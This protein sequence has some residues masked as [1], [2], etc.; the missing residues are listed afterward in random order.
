[1]P[2]L[3]LQPHR[4][5]FQLPAYLFSFSTVSPPFCL[6]LR[7]AAFDGLGKS[8][9]SE[10]HVLSSHT[11]ARSAMQCTLL[12]TGTAAQQYSIAVLWAAVATTWEIRFAWIC[13]WV[14]AWKSCLTHVQWHCCLPRHRT[15]RVQ[16][17][18]ATCFPFLLI[19][20]KS[21]SIRVSLKKCCPFCLTLCLL[22]LLAFLFLPTVCSRMGVMD[23]LWLF[24]LAGW[25]DVLSEWI[26]AQNL[27]WSWYKVAIIYFSYSIEACDFHLI[28]L[29]LLTDSC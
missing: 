4:W 10:K 16:K 24:V 20:C 25:P 28:G 3:S 2:F 13:F 22:C 21:L 29:Q 9:E 14:T 17:N 23:L 26:F 8:E 11:V 7:R 27:G 19:M 15:E 18:P 6:P 12:E 5:H 1:M